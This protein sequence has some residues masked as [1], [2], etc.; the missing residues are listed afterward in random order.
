MPRKRSN[1][2]RRKDGRWEGRIKM[3]TKN[4]KTQY[5]SIYGKSYSSVRELMDE[6]E[7]NIIKGKDQ[8][9][10]LLFSGILD[11]W[12]QDNS[13]RIK[14]STLLKYENVINCH[15]KPCLGDYLVSALN[16]VILNQFF[17]SKISN[18]RKSDN[19]RLSASYVKTMYL[20]VASALKYAEKNNYCRKMDFEIRKIQD[21]KNQISALSFC[22]QQKL[23]NYI[24]SNYS[25]TGLG[26]LLSLYTGMR[27]GEICAL[28]WEDID[29]SNNIIYV[30]HT[31]AR[32]KN[33]N[34][35]TPKT[36]LVIDSAKSA[37]SI[38][39]IPISSYLIPL[40][41]RAKSESESD[42]VISADRTFVH[43]RTFENRF[44]K[45]LESAEIKS[46]KFHNLRHTFATRC[47]ENGANAKTVSEILGHSSVNITLNT[48]VHSSLELKRR[49]IEKLSCC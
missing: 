28:R 12:L 11:L 30:K 27:I 45:L 35:E 3:G 32:I 37:S 47:I 40:L 20:I 25:L 6:T 10:E 42:F 14:N 46:T 26:I 8:Y 43:P 18:G 23:E 33:P 7:Q 39:E 44:H 49:E 15:I 13:F 36:V 5:R 17:E 24:G 4:G 21:N 41:T 29:F 38:R 16:T 22:E 34:G 9:H 19:C 31:I 1:I 2:Y 48:Y